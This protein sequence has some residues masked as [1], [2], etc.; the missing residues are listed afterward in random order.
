MNSDERL[1]M[2]AAENL[3]GKKVLVRL[4]HPAAEHGLGQTYKAKD[5][6]AIIDVDPTITDDDTTLS[7]FLHE[8]AHVVK[9]LAWMPRGDFHLALPAA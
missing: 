8:C 2:L 3:T 7:I 5:G 1:M 9:D 6:S 4:R